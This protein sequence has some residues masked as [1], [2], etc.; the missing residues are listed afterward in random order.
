MSTFFPLGQDPDPEKIHAVYLDLKARRLAQLQLD[1][2]SEPEQDLDSLY[3]DRDALD[4]LP[5]PDPLIPAVLPRHAYGVLRGRDQSF[6]SFVALDWALSLATGQ[7]W[8]LTPVQRV[9]VLYVAGEG[10]WGLRARVAAWEASRQTRVDPS[11]FTVRQMA[12]NMHR[13]GPAFEH[14][15]EHVEQRG[16][17]LVVVDTLRR[18]SGAADGNG[19]EMGAV[20]DSLDQVKH[21]TAGGTV[22]VVAHTD[23]GDSDSRGYSGIEDDADFVWHARREASRLELE[24]TKMKD[25]PDGITLHMA[26][27][28][29][30]ESLVLVHAT[31]E[32]RNE[33]TES[34]AT[35]LATMHQ[36]FPEGAHKGAL[37]ETSGLPQSTFYRAIKALENRQQVVKETVRMHPFW[38]PVGLAPSLPVSAAPERD[39]HAV[40]QASQGVSPVSRP[41][42]SETLRM[43]AEEAS[44]VGEPT[45]E[46]R[47]LLQL[48]RGDEVGS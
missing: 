21:A 27:Q 48:I 5:Q 11:W 12:L 44:T 16:Y 13:P 7:M 31:P 14:L 30:D 6:K 32:A 1:V 10:A 28:L 29:V 34:E 22:L 17:G 15:L 37:I 9:P 23:K 35:L 4:R 41:L 42:G 36:L 26:A 45:Q 46:Q 3:L 47:A 20:V 24:L 33:A 25:G 19:S 38:R 43:R 18:V 2:E 39:S 40:S 8:N